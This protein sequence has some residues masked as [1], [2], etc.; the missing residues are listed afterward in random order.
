M[1]PWQ[2]FGLC[3]LPTCPDFPG[4]IASSVILGFRSCLP[5][6]GSSG[7]SPDSLFILLAEKPWSAHH[8]LGQ[9][10]N[11]GYLLWIT[12][13]KRSISRSSTELCGK[14]RNTTR[15]LPKTAICCSPSFHTNRIRR[16]SC[17]PVCMLAQRHCQDWARRLRS[18]LIG[19]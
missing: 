16:L 4:F 17:Q 3:R 6:R 8:I 10:L 2:V 1:S 11:Q 14:L 12:I 18:N 13:P 15:T 7:F 5:L 9:S 19:R